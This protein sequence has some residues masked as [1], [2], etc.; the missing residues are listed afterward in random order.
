VRQAY[1]KQSVIL[2]Y[3]LSSVA[4]QNIRWMLHS[5]TLPVAASQ[6]YTYIIPH[7][8]HTPGHA[9]PIDCSLTTLPTRTIALLPLHRH[10]IYTYVR[11]LL[12][13]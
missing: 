10:Y 12:A 5:H 9:D 4:G 11:R 8:P 2:N 3:P 7:S 1:I 6:C 13:L